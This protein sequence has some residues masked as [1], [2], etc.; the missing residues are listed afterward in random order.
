MTRK[1][2]PDEDDLLLE[3]INI[4]SSAVLS[5]RIATAQAVR[6]LTLFV[7]TPVTRPCVFQHRRNA[8]D[9]SIPDS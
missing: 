4:V 3:I 7:A 5:D 8:A 9:S 6:D 1:H 2:T